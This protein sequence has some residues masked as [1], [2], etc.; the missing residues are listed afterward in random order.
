MT[1]K[2][3]QASINTGIQANTVK[4]DVLAVG[5]GASAVKLGDSAA[6]NKELAALVTELRSALDRLPLQTSAREA[7][8]EDVAKLDSAAKERNP[9]RTG[10]ILESITGKLKMVGVAAQHAIEIAG[11]L[12]KIAGLLGVPVPW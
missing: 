6:A 9:E 11:P 4:A 10:N 8:E 12:M 5:E 1:A 3:R 2:Q 7:I